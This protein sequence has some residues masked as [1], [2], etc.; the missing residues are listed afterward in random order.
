MDLERL[1]KSLDVS[2]CSH[3]V[4]VPCLGEVAW[5]RSH[6]DARERRRA[7]VFF[8]ANLWDEG[9]GESVRRA[10]VVAGHDGVAD[11]GVAL[12]DLQARG[13]RSEIFQAVVGRLADLL[14][15]E[16]RRAFSAA[17]N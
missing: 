5:S 4:C 10:L 13:L 6:G 12:D 8:A 17:L 7:Y 2:L 14:A 15:E 3:G 16:T 11:A 1:L 9:L